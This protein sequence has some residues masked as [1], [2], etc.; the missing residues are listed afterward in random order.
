[1]RTFTYRWHDRTGEHAG[2]HDCR[3]ELTL[4]RLI[5]RAG[6]ELIMITGEQEK[7]PDDPMRFIDE[8]LAAPPGRSIGVTI[9]AFFSLVGAAVPAAMLLGLL[10]LPAFIPGFAQ[11]EAAAGGNFFI[12]Y[13]ITAAVVAANLAIGIGLLKLKRWARLAMLYF[14]WFD[15]AVSTLTTLVFGSI[16]IPFFGIIT[17]VFFGRPGVKRQFDPFAEDP[18]GGPAPRRVK[19]LIVLG[20]LLAI[21]AGILLFRSL[22][23]KPSA[24]APAAGALPASPEAP[25]K[26]TPRRPPLRLSGIIPGGKAPRAIINDTFVRAGDEVGG[27]KVVRVEKK[28]V[29]MSRD[30]GEFTLE[31]E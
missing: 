8:N 29:V 7:A 19:H 27:A 3:D 15:I 30:G 9:F 11:I 2:T 28:S 14:G 17:I 20:V 10:F 23:Q 24:P 6:G 22:S 25:A 26:T 21:V 5:R 4:R 1:M 12:L 31:M 16:S 13:A 18:A